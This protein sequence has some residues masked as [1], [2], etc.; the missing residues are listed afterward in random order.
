MI[1][2]INLYYKI[3]TQTYKICDKVAYDMLTAEFYS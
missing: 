3:L 2:T 1:S